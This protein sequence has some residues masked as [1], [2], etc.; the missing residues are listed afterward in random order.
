M[1][2][3]SDNLPI[4]TNRLTGSTEV[5][6]YGKWNAQNDQETKEKIKTVLPLSEQVKVTGN[7][8]LNGYGSF[9]GRIYNGSNRTITDMIIRIIAKEK[10]GSVRWDRRFKISTYIGP[11]STESIIFSVTGDEGVWSTDWN[12]EEIRGDE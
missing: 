1:T 12:I 3:G 10:N 2:I 4:R 11:L 8:S 6:L 9:V 7:A 5:F